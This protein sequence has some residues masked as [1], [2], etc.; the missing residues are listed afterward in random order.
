MEWWLYR[1]FNLLLDP[2]NKNIW[3]EKNNSSPTLDHF[4]SDKYSE[5]TLLEFHL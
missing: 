3:M 4:R 5:L 1:V 2:T